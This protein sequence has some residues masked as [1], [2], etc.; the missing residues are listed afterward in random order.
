MTHN[1]LVVAGES[2]GDAHAAEL[3][4]QMRILAEQH[5]LAPPRFQGMGG[6]RLAAVGVAP[7][8]RME[9]I[10]VIG[11]VE[12]IRHLP[13]I[14]RTFRGLVAR[15]DRDRPDIAILV[16]FPDFNLRL[17][18]Q[19]VRRKIPVIWY[20]SP[21]VW[22]WRSGRIRQLKPLVTKM[23]VLFPFE[24]QFYAQH[25][26]DVTFVGHP[27][28]DRV[29]AF[30]EADRLSLRQQFGLP[31]EGR[32]V[33]LLPGSRRSELRHYLT[34]MLA[35]AEYLVRQDAS[36]CFV[37]PRAPSLDVADF[38]NALRRV[39]SPVTLTSDA[40]Y[41][42][43]AL[44]DA[45]VVASGTATLETALVGVPMVIVGKV[46]PLT[47]MYLRRFAPLPYVGLVNYV[48][49]EAAV[50]ELLQEQVSGENIARQLHDLLHQTAQRERLQAIYAAIR[51]RLGEGGASARAAQAV[52]QQLVGGQSRDTATY[53]QSSQIEARSP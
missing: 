48:M 6:E 51:M 43:L 16:D 26:M 3:V 18:R 11:I 14:W 38:T 24:V 47:A 4:Q 39:S 31:S 45:A 17:A 25:G 52:W 19:L 41:E 44:A 12:V 8:V 50:P 33:A 34:P 28:L 15:L 9:A 13:T 5:G 23:L 42:T 10:S 53:H 32:V 7:L 1:I 27:L 21:Q 2:S 46:A 29:P 36:V 30:T 35:A 40:F 20:I 37:L 49:G 22:A